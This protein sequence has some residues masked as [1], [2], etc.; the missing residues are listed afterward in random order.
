MK[1]YELV[2]CIAE[3]IQDV[4]QY[5]FPLEKYLKRRDRDSYD[6]YKKMI[7]DSPA[8]RLSKGDLSW[9]EVWK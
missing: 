6:K 5:T 2:L 9:S 7:M 1:E 3:R 8:M 4:F